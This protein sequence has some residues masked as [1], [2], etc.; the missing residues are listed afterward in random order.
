MTVLRRLMLPRWPVPH[1]IWSGYRQS[2]LLDVLLPGVDD[3]VH[4]AGLKP[5]QFRN[6]VPSIELRIPLLAGVAK[7]MRDPINVLSQLRNNTYAQ[8]RQRFAELETEAG[9][10][11]E[12][13]AP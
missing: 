7:V 11:T 4:V 9:N 2:R 12:P 5:A 1:E 13:L 6:F 10:G 3:V 8:D